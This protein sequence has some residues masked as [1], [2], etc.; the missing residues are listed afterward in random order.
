MKE[1]WN[2]YKK[3]IV[4]FLLVKLILVLAIF[5]FRTSVPFND[6]EFLRNRHGNN[7]SVTR[8]QFFAF[9]DGQWYQEIA[10]MGYRKLYPI[11]ANYA[12]F[13]LYPIVL[14]NVGIIF[15]GNLYFAGIFI[16]FLFSFLATLFLYKIFI[17]ETEKETALRGILLFL[18]Y[19]AGIFYLAL[20]NESL[21]LFLAL[22]SIYSARKKYWWMAGIA[23]FLAALTRPQGVLLFIPVVIEYVVALK[24]I[25]GFAG[26]K[27]LMKKICKQGLC[28][29]PLLIPLGLGAFFLY[30]L[31]TTRDFFAP[32]DA[33]RFFSRSEMSFLNVGKVLWK[34]FVQFS[35][36]PWFDFKFSRVD[37]LASIFSLSLLIPV[38]RRIRLS[39]ACYAL[40]LVFLPLSSG[41]TMSMMR[42]GALLF[43][44][45]LLLGIITKNR[46]YLMI[47]LSG[48]FVALEIY[49]ALRFTNYNWVS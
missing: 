13:P 15:A 30:S 11:H 14:K 8:I 19:P 43:P 24:E 16:S 32:I 18:L 12:F 37:Y 45:F 47:L 6:H 21:F 48:I 35:H 23:G 36:L 1:F 33:Q 44:H 40:T 4:I 31:Y 28:I 10:N 3:I 29:A 27:E 25:G 46:R 38:F 34:G 26:A 41:L 20:Y 2:N 17:L 42:Y 9:W 7:Q 22:A 39:Y 49:F 5:F